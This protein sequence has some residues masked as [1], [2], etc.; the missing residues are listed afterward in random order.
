MKNLTKKDVYVKI[1]RSNV[2]EVAKLLDSAGEELFNKQSC[3]LGE[4]KGYRYIEFS[5]SG[6]WTRTSYF[7][8]TREEVTLEQL[9]EIL[10]VRQF[11]IGDR[12]K[13]K[14]SSQ[15]H[16]YNNERNPR[17]TIGAIFQFCD[18]GCI[19]VEWGV[20]NKN[21]YL[22]EDLELVTEAK[23]EQYISVT[24]ENLGGIY[25]AVC[26]GWKAK[27]EE[28][29]EKADKFAV[30][31]DVPLTLLKKAYSEANAAQTELLKEIAPL[32][33]EKVTVKVSRW[34]NIYEESYSIVSAT[35]G[36]GNMVYKTKKD[37]IL[38]KAQI[39]YITTIELTG[40]Y[41]T[42]V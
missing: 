39:G 24:R 13:I 4:T 35:D 21:S 10:G 19:R 2:A 38:N 41:E 29:L 42:E 17:N 15:Y 6:E 26:G 1:D 23:P 30:N 20:N 27:I 31:V 18:N 14:E 25:N 22:P 33:K 40:E 7:Y 28:L 36:I 9:A 3:L 11:K 32:P 5:D 16:H 34:V 37:A 8:G 12:V